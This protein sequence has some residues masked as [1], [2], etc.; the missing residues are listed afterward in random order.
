LQRKDYPSMSYLFTPLSIG[1]LEL[2]NRV[3]VSPMCQ[4]SADDGVAGDWH[5]QHLV[6]YGYS[7]AGL[8]TVE[9]TAVERRG[10]ITHGCLGL[11]SDACEAML[12][13]AISAARRFSGPVRFGIQLAHAG[14]K[15][16]ANRPWERGGMPLS[17]EE[18]PWA[19]E[20]P[21]PL[22]FAPGWPVPNALDEKG[23]DRI[24]SA[25]V[26]AARRAARIGFDLVEIH[27][28]HG[29]LLHEFLSP[30]ANQRPDSFGG[31]LEN[32]MRFPLAVSRAVRDSLPS[33]IVVGART[34]ATDWIEGG[35]TPEEAVIFSRELRSIGAEYVCVSSGGIT[36]P[37]QVPVSPGYHA[38]FAGRIKKESGIATQAV[39]MILTPVQAEEIIE[40]GQADMVCLARAFLDDPRWVWHAAERLGADVHYPPQY[41]RAK[42]A[43]WP[44]AVLVRP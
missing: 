2:V 21:S 5:L 27:C 1:P 10:R 24:L 8:V 14:R 9:A 15:G 12:S 26:D 31:N 37:L 25:F 7:G 33:R 6:Q 35:W 39:G 3:V 16:S 44:G 13:R 17:Y 20:G 42:R 4:Y 22:P 19:T 28:A 30:I 40:S 34:T 38:P 29:Y 43:V 36:Q 11:Y 41:E 32:R 18:D 23:M